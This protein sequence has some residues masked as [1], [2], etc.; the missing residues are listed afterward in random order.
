MILD[1]LLLKIANIAMP[2]YFYDYDD[3]SFLKVLL[4]MYRRTTIIKYQAYGGGH[5]L[6]MIIM[7][8]NA[9]H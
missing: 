9:F 7:D 1:L 4:V 5:C 8:G 3:V 2:L 6:L